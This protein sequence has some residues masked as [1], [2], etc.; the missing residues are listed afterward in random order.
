MI[1]R[2]SRVRRIARRKFQSAPYHLVR[3]LS[4]AA[5]T[6]IAAS[7][8]EPDV[9]V[10]SIL[11]PDGTA[12]YSLAYAPP[13]GNI[14]VNVHVEAASTTA[15]LL[16]ELGVRLVRFSANWY[17]SWG[18]PNYWNGMFQEYANN[19]IDVLATVAFRYRATTTFADSG[20]AFSHC[21][22]RPLPEGCIPKE[23]TP[24][25]NA[26]LA[27]WTQFTTALVNANAWRVKYW[28]PWNEP[29]EAFFNGTVAQY[30]ALATV[31]CRAVRDAR[32]NLG[33]P[34]YCVGPEYGIHN[35][36][37]QAQIE[38][39]AP[40]VLADSFDVLALHVYDWQ[41][42]LDAVA[43]Y[44]KQRIP[45]P[46]WITE[47]GVPDP[48]F[49]PPAMDPEFHE[50]DVVQKAQYMR[51]LYPPGYSRPVDALFFFDLQTNYAGL[52]D[53]AKSWDKRP[54]YHALKRVIAGTYAQPSPGFCSG[55]S[56]SVPC[57]FTA[58]PVVVGSD[59][60]DCVMRAH[61]TTL[62]WFRFYPVSGATILGYETPGHRNF[63]E[64]LTDSQGNAT[65]A[66]H[67]TVLDG[68]AFVPGGGWSRSSPA[69]NDQLEWS[70]TNIRTVEFRAYR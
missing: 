23:N 8:R 3:A 52:L 57:D 65:F 37:Y 50:R 51:R 68:L 59:H 46:L 2:S 19:G 35:D 26:F 27:D 10:T 56:G 42:Q 25:W 66:A 32:V 58:N 6:F 30:D 11:R 53:A 28:S 43:T 15:P 29:N 20:A 49:R 55:A 44:A 22:D 9:G 60:W 18:D 70:Q 21:V 63:G 39:L 69:Y 13:A 14:G 41:P 36:G 40:R 64:K 12:H 62:A 67:C 34:V 38:A 17:D 7:C 45:L 47:T 48:G 1:T 5:L 31:F 33:A 16:N 54:A 24:E 61:V 4:A